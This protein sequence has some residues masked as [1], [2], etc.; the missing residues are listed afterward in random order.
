MAGERSA[1]SMMSDRRFAATTA[2][3]G[4]LA[5]AHGLFTWP[6][7]ATIALFGGGAIVAFVGEAVVINRGWLEHHI[8]P[9]VL[10]V[11]LY[12]L[13]GWTAVAYVAVRLALLATTG[14]ATVP[15]AAGLATLFDLL[16]D[17][18]GVAAGYWTFTDGPP[19]P[20]YRGV[21]W[22]NFVG[23]ILV[24]ATTATIALAVL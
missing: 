22:W 17:H 4:L 24:T 15:L 11:P 20:R 16:T 19:G 2:A 13:F 7:E 5:L 18:Y 12:V 9:K 8:G 3:L 21:P 1:P 6:L 10:G 23:W 14:W